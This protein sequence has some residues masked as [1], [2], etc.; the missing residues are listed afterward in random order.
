[1]RSA[2]P[3]SVLSIPLKRFAPEGFEWGRTE[4]QVLPRISVPGLFDPVFASPK[5]IAADDDLISPDAIR[6]RLLAL[7][8]ALDICRA[9]PSGW[10]A[11]RL[12][13]PRRKSA[14][15]S[16]FRPGFAPG[17]HRHEEREIDAIL[18]DCHYFAR[19]AWDQPDTS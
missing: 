18:G 10:R 9:R 17:Y 5:P 2:S 6:R 15:P 1:M 4:A 19:E 16:P 3:P 14:R 8:H 11:G 13:R 7:R 12:G